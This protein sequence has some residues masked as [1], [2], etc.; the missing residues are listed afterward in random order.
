MVTISSTFDFGFLTFFAYL[1]NGISELKCASIEGLT[2]FKDSSS[3][4]CY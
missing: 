2:T 1:S 4:E 3:K